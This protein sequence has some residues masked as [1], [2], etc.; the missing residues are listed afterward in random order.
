MLSLGAAGFSPPPPGGRGITQWP[1][2]RCP[3]ITA[4]LVSSLSAGGLKDRVSHHVAGGSLDALDPL[5]YAK[6]NLFYPH[7]VQSFCLPS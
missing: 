1:A 4:I 7:K 6:R 5:P 3:H 2:P